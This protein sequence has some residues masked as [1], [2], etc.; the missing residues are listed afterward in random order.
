[1]GDELVSL[2]KIVT[3]VVRS[4][5]VAVGTV[6]VVVKSVDLQRMEMEPATVYIHVWSPYSFKE[7][8][9][10]SLTH[11]HQ[12]FHRSGKA[13]AIA[14]FLVSDFPTLASYMGGIKLAVFVNTHE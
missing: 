5:L 1:M 11:G 8:F 7:L 10:G 4:G 3:A 6:G 12:S 2:A 13:V 14:K 9:I